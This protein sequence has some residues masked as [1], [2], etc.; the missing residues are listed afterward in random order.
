MFNRLKT[1]VIVAAMSVTATAGSQAQ[2]A[3]ATATASIT[4]RTSSLLTFSNDQFL[5]DASTPFNSGF[6]AGS[7]MQGYFFNQNGSYAE[8]DNS[9]S[10][11]PQTHAGALSSGRGSATVLWTFDYTA[12]GDGTAQLNLEYLY[13]ATVTGWSAGETGIARSY[14]SVLRDGS[15]DN[16]VALNF[17]QNSNNDTSGFNN[18]VLNFAVTSGQT[19]TFTVT[20]TSDAVAAPVPLPAAAWLLGSA[21]TGLGVVGRRRT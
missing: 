17:F 20:V 5:S 4:D 6:D 3:T 10:P 2:A 18:L 9:F 16:L 11:L 19:G 12:T 1:F 21:L 15:P 13:S 8:I 7:V 14:V